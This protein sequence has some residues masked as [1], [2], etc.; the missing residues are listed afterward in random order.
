ML[1]R[2]RTIVFLISAGLV[3]SSCTQIPPR[4]KY[5]LNKK[6]NVDLPSLTLPPKQEIKRFVYEGIKFQ[7]PFIPLDQSNIVIVQKDNYDVGID[8]ASLQFKG[9]IKEDKK[10]IALLVDTAGNTYFLK[11][12]KLIDLKGRVIPGVAGVCKDES[13]V[14]ETEDGDTREIKLYE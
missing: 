9:F 14:I 11:N 6:S 12:M 8:P 7:D 4:P 10:T 1:F 3:V 2:A 5:D 13:V